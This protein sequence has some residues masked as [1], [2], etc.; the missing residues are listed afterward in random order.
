MPCGA[1]SDRRRRRATTFRRFAATH[2]Q[3]A[4]AL[5]RSELKAARE[6]ASEFLEEAEDTGHVVEASIAR[7][8]PFS[9]ELVGAPELVTVNLVHMPACQW[10]G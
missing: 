8:R 10:P 1:M 9:Y 7:R 2:G 6:L 5:V 4:L 3:W